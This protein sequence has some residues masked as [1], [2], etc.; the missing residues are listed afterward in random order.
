M[1]KPPCPVC[2]G[3]CVSPEVHEALGLKPGD[4]LVEILHVPLYTRTPSPRF[5][6]LQARIKAAKTTS[7][8]FD[9]RNDAS[10]GV[11]LGLLDDE[12]LVTLETLIDATWMYEPL[13]DDPYGLCRLVLRSSSGQGTP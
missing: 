6:S 2:V 3:T 13:T 10:L 5:L 11:I 8:L 9:I 1:D 12:D 7:D 4:S